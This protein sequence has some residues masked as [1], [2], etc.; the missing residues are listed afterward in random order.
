MP[1][2]ATKLYTVE[3]W[4]DL[5]LE[6]TERT[7][8]V[9]GEIA[10]MGNARSIHEKQKTK[11]LRALSAYLDSRP[12]LGEVYAETMYRLE[13]GTARI[14]DVSV[15]LPDRAATDGPFEGAPEIAIEVVSSETADQLSRKLRDY[16]AH[17]AKL[18]IHVHLDDRG[19]FAYASDGTY[20]WYGGSDKFTTPLLPGFAV[21][22]SD[23]FAA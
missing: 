13:P 7:E 5:P 11:W 14:P 19:F 3:E 10:A 20:R 12:G 23:L 4:M 9:D 6:Q 18:V 16:L 15:L 8:L 2:T 1:A 22:V 17:G 21:I